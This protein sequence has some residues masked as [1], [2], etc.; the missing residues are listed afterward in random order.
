MPG[1]I[2]LTLT[3]QEMIGESPALKAVL[4]QAKRVAMSDA[5]VLLLGEPGSG[6]ESIARAIHRMS[7]RRYEGF[8][9]INCS[10][11]PA[12]RF[13][14]KLFGHG[15]GILASTAAPKAGRLEL[16][17]NGTLFLDEV[18]DFPLDFQPK[19]LRVLRERKFKTLNSTIGVTA[20]VI[21]ATTYQL[22]KQGA[23]HRFRSDLHSFLKKV[24]IQV[25]SLRQ[26]R[27]DI[28]LLVRYFVQ[29]FAQRMKK[30][31]ETI[32]ADTMDTLMTRAWPGNVRELEHFIERAV[33]F[34]AGP[35]LQL[36]P[37]GVPS[38]I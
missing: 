19:L 16:A 11:I 2:D 36:P 14:S 28:P 21:A 37:L 32:P 9:K 1:K 34:T 15:E 3:H 7:P 22:E 24:S 38:T 4:E 20:R 13:E 30:R 35:T 5:T 33:T 6:K 26:R 18:A 10:V 12:E 8:I 23:D 17:S 27:E 25:P 31:I 29:M